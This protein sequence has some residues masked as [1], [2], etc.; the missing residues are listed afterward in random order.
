MPTLAADPVI[1]KGQD[2]WKA[3]D[4]K[5]T[6]A[7]GWASSDFIAEGWKDASTPLGYGK[8]P[9]TTTL[10]FG[11]D[12]KK[13]HA[14]AY[15]RHGFKVEEVAA[16]YV[17]K[18]RM[19]DGAVFHVNGKEVH[20]LNVAKA[21]KPGEYSK[22]ALGPGVLKQES[23]L[24]LEPDVVKVGENVLAIALFQSGPTSSDLY[25][26]L[27][28][29]PIDKETFEKMKKEVAERK[30]RREDAEKK[31]AEKKNAPTA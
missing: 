18:V 11:E 23:T 21:T 27:D 12:A 15:L 5:A 13:K 26:D 9:V 24:I 30:K 6:P 8:E 1:K 19:D 7:E 20:R 25:L 2:G 29:T 28:I 4:Q 17:I 31:A 14:T 3:W 16:A 10:S 22:F